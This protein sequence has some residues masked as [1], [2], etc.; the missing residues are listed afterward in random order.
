MHARPLTD[1]GVVVIILWNDTYF[2][3]LR[4]HSTDENPV[5]FPNTWC[6]VTGGVEVGENTYH[7]AAVRELGEEIGFL[8]DDFHSLGRS[9]KH[10]GFFLCRLSNE[11]VLRIRLGEGQ[12]Y[13]FCTFEKLGGLDIRAA[14]GI[15]LQRYQDIFRRIAEDS[16]F[17]PTHSDLGLH[18]FY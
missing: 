17:V 6:P 8:P 16:S 11:E 7:E 4:D 12:C 5:S 18:P 14:F 13:A 10:N 9:E 15:Y 3:I 1:S 2:L